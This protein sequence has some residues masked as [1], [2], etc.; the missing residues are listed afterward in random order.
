MAG[1]DAKDRETRLQIVVYK[2]QDFKYRMSGLRFGMGLMAQR[3]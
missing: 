2:V 1:V 3:L